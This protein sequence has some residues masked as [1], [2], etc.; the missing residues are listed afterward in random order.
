MPAPIPAAEFESIYNY[1]YLWKDA[2]KEIKE[3]TQHA[4]VSLLGSNTPAVERYSLLSKVNAS[5]LRTCETA[6]G[7]YQGAS[8]LLLPKNLYIDFADLLLDD[9]LP[10]QLWV[11]IGIINSDEK[12]SVYTYGMKEFGKSEI[13]IIDAK[14]KGSELYDFLLPVLDYVL[15][16][17]VTLRHGETIGFTEEQKIKITESKAVYLDGNSLKL[18]L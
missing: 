2:E 10:I 16:Q 12:S 18:E 9:M 17:D 13:E 11:Y 7:I 5:I 14:M 1:S 8:T 3:H 6:I 4:I 15:R